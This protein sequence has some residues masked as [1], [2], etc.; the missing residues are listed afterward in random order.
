MVTGLSLIG[1]SLALQ[2]PGPNVAETFS[3]ELVK[4]RRAIAAREREQLTSLARQARDAGD[5]EG[6]A[7]DRL[8]DIEA[9]ARPEPLPLTTTP[10]VPKPNSSMPS[11][12]ALTLEPLASAV[13][14]SLMPNMALCTWPPLRLAAV[15]TVGSMN[16]PPPVL[17]AFTSQLCTNN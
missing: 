6:A 8:R 12:T 15:G 9:V 16:T 13:A 11:T 14:F 2:I 10:L 1:L 7:A 3:A 17:L 4:A 5:A